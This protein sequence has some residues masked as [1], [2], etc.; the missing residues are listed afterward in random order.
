MI[1]ELTQSEGTEV[2]KISIEDTLVS[3]S[4]ATGGSSYLEDLPSPTPRIGNISK[5]LDI[6]IFLALSLT[7]LVKMIT[8]DTVS[9]QAEEVY[10]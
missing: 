1:E 10:R 8:G 5:C 3:T 2:P 7:L 6:R 4:G 9:I